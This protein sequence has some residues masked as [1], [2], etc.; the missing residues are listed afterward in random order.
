MRKPLLFSFFIVLVFM[1]CS[2]VSRIPVDVLKPASISMPGVK[3]VAVVDF[4]GEKD[5]GSQIATLVQSRLLEGGN[6]DIME[7]DKITKVLEEQNLGMSG[8]V[9][10]ETAVSVGEMLGVDAM[11]FGKVTTYQVDPDKKITEKV[12]EKKF[13]GKYR[14]VTKKDNKSGKEKKV[15]EKI[16]EDVFVEKERW[17]R[18]GTV[19]INFRVVNVKTGKLLAAHSESESYDSDNVEYT[20]SQKL[21]GED[22]KLK[23]RGEILADL[24]ES[25]CTKFVR[26]IAPY[27]VREMRVIESGE[28]NIDKGRKFAEN[29]LW[30]EAIAAWKKA[31]N[32]S[33]VKPA[34]YYNLGVAHEVRG[35]FDLA[36]KYYKEAL[37]AK[38]KDLY[39]E[40]LSRLRRARKE[41]EKLQ[42]QL[43]SK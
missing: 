15:K 42:K 18:Q 26:M 43:Q 14:T 41:Q 28:G 2:S 39:I 9:D 24:S 16:Y 19:A 3:E 12:K 1:S 13:S 30:P 40:S 25:I 6:F 29:G 10:R 36:E 33:S 8:I 17:I 11:I 21:K 37:S 4:E 38:S 35:E 22:K 7:R 34:V 31:L 23:P 20:F 5:S 32:S 27:Q